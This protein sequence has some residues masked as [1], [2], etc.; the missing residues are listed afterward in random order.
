[1]KITEFFIIIITAVIL[2]AITVIIAVKKKKTKLRYA[3]TAVTLI[4]AV[5]SVINVILYQKAIEH[6]LYTNDISITKMLTGINNSPN[7]DSLPNDINDLKGCIIIYYRFGCKDCEGIYKELTQY[8]SDNNMTVRFI[9]TRSQQGQKLMKIYPIQ[10]VPTGIYIHKNQT[11][12]DEFTKKVLY[13]QT[14]NGESKLLTE[15]IERL[16]ELQNEH[17]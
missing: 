16:K 1:M 17:F 3:M 4:C 11:G 13:T 9:S 6:G 12:Y 14:E 8:I 10:E 15:A 7:E 2:S 5:I